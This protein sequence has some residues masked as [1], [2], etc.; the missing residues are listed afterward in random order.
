MN[1]FGVRNEDNDVN[2]YFIRHGQSC[3]NYL[4]ARG[5]IKFDPKLTDCGIARSIAYGNMLR[6]KLNESGKQV[7]FL[8]SSLLRRAIETAKLICSPK[9]IC[10]FIIY[11]MLENFTVQ[12]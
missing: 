8:G 12:V 5:S 7:H 4:G 9:K 11:H 2:I 10:L 1:N 6:S 3:S